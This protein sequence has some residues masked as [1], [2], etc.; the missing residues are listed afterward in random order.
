MENLR[1][2][3]KGWLVSLFAGFSIGITPFYTVVRS[4]VLF[5]LIT[6][7]F[8]PT[9][10][11]FS[12]YV[13]FCFGLGL[14]I[15]LLVTKTLM[16]YLN[17]LVNRSF[18]LDDEQVM[19][20]SSETHEEIPPP[21]G[22]PKKLW[23]LRSTFP[24]N[25]VITEEIFSDLLNQGFDTNSIVLFFKYVRNPSLIDTIRPK[26]QFIPIKKEYIKLCG[27]VCRLPFSRQTLNALFPG[28][29]SIRYL[30]YLFF[31]ATAQESLISVILQYLKLYE[32]I[33]ISI[34]CGFS[35]YSL[36]S[37]PEVDPYSTTKGDI[38]TGITRA[39]YITIFATVW[40]I[41]APL[42]KF[43]PEYQYIDTFKMYFYWRHVCGIITDSARIALLAFPLMLIFL[44]PLPATFITWALEGLS[45][46]LYGLSGAAGFTHSITQFA[47]STVVYVILYFIVRKITPLRL[48]G[49]IGIALLL[50]QFPLSFNSL[51]KKKMVKFYLVIFCS[52]LVGFV[53][54]YSSAVMAYISFESITTVSA[55]FCAVL[56]FLW[57]LM[58]ANSYYVLFYM[59]II[60]KPSK[61]INA[62]RLLTPC[63]FTPLFIGGILQRWNSNPVVSAL[64]IVAAINNSLC[65]SYIMASAIIL[66]RITFGIELAM[67][68][69]AINLLL[70]MMLARKLLSISTIIDYW[71]RG[72]LAGF[73]LFYD[74]Y[75]SDSV[76]DKIKDYI[77]TS[78]FTVIPGPD[79][80][81]TTPAFVW[82]AMTGAPFLS[83]Q[84]L[85]LFMLPCSP[86][87][88]C[89][90]DYTTTQDDNIAKPFI[91]ALTEH[92]VEAPVYTSLTRAL[93]MNLAIMIR[94]GTLG[95]V[96]S[97]DFFLFLSEPLAAFVHIIALEPQGVRFQVRGLEYNDETLCHLGEIAHLKDDV[98]LYQDRVPNF[99][100]QLTYAGT[101]WKTRAT[102][103]SLMQYNV[104]TIQLSRAFLGVEREKTL[105][106]AALTFCNILYGK[107][108]I[109]ID[110]DQTDCPEILSRVISAMSLA[111]DKKKAAKAF[112]IFVDLT[113]DDGFISTD[114]IAE[115]F[116]QKIPEDA[117][118]SFVA[119]HYPAAQLFALVLALDAMQMSPDT[120]DIDECVAFVEEVTTQYMSAPITSKE[121]Q[122]TFKLE[123]SDLFSITERSGEKLA[124]FFKLTSVSYDVIHIQREFVR[125]FWASEA[126]LQIFLGEDNSERLSI[127][128]DDHML[129]N[130]ILQACDLPIGYP[131]LVSPIK[132]SFVPS[133][134]SI[135]Y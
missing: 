126:F 108:T 88:N 58:C 111:V 42:E 40:V 27:V 99:M 18:V 20:E 51:I 129:H 28:N 15:P 50:L 100:S 120:D 109:V 103:V 21:P 43:A 102:N 107:E 49:A 131:A 66:E 63:F 45:Y 132:S 3:R 78:V 92:P 71:R 61:T 127:Q 75:Y 118:A 41:F 7:H 124:V 116:I 36:L 81:L 86:R 113:M 39:F 68:N 47:R 117:D 62:L 80:V 72:R 26:E 52:S 74:T 6:I 34:Y 30:I 69:P 33:I 90:W 119:L 56:D 84:N 79:K 29:T 19:T 60:S 4:L 73:Y 83:P 31:L 85:S 9:F 105:F 5:F 37:P 130:L 101:N 59:K 54:S 110:E 133:P 65:Q 98:S 135:F 38:M 23:N 122:K 12:P 128:E 2:L 94:N 24:S 55:L 123:E 134:F 82:S 22:I 64:I 112:E 8:L 14:S 46:Y 77:A 115:F 96:D 32:R 93:T 44:L 87:P 1:G 53:S 91:V 48:S 10:V 106:W 25:V 67:P 121:F 125:S 89:F 13:G 70:A 95:I 35:L 104:V 97:N 11:G 114:N 16:Y 17:S 76:K 57:P